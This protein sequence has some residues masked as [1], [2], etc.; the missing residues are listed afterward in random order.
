MQVKTKAIVLSAIKFQESSLIV[1][2]FTQSDGLKSYLIRSAFG[3]KSAKVGGAKIA[4]FQPMTLL[5]IDAVHKNKGTLEQVKEVKIYWP[6]QTIPTDI[7]KSSILL[8]LAEMLQHAIHEEEKNS[9]FFAFLEA[10]LLWLDTHQETANFHLV[11][12][13]EA[14]KYLGFYPDTSQEELP[15]FNLQ[16]GQFSNTLSLG[17]LT[18]QETDLLKR[19]LY[20]QF[21]SD[22]KSF[23][24][25]ERQQLL[26]IIID[27][28][29]LHLSGFK[30]PKSLEVLKEVF[31]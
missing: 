31:S 3:S 20:L 4:Y 21:D 30:K 2:C 19:G 29:V 16:E 12:L 9:D 5:E 23:H 8:F 27:Y 10:A 24:V 7:V 28:Y 15:Y 1:K 25:S 22:Q 26:K 14:T 18:E 11:L 17:T 6:Y 13:L